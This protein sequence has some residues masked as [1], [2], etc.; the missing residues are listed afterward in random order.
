MT[1]L[2][3]LEKEEKLDWNGIKSGDSL[4]IRI[5]PAEATRS[6]ELIIG[7]KHA[8]PNQ[9]NVQQRNVLCSVVHHQA[10]QDQC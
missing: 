3:S 6:Q 2:C 9:R 4:S 7:G 5:R 1:F 10:R 8:L